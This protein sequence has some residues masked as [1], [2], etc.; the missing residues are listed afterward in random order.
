MIKNIFL[1]SPKGEFI[2]IFSLFFSI[3]LFSANIFITPDD[4]ELIFYKLRKDFKSARN[5]QISVN[6]ISS[7]KISYILKR[8]LNKNKNIKL[9]VYKKSL[10]NDNSII[11]YLQIYKNIEVKTLTGIY[12]NIMNINMIILDNS[13]VYIFSNKFSKV[14]FEKSYGI[15]SRFTDLNHVKK[16]RNIFS[17]LEERAEEIK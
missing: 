4:S 1:F 11:P 15:V 14:D 10:K 12:N 6:G 9:I 2:F 7:K 8:A 5:I 17:I 16:F 13:V 3:S